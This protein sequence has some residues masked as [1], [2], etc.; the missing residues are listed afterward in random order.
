MV[1]GVGISC[2]TGCWDASRL[3]VIMFVVGV[4]VSWLESLGKGG[5]VPPMEIGGLK[6]S[7]PP[8][9]GDLDDVGV[10]VCLDSTP[11]EVPIREASGL[12]GTSLGD[13]EHSRRVRFAPLL[14]LFELDKNATASEG[15]CEVAQLT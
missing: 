5:W 13:F 12:V 1:D 4:E 8:G 14:P 6:G 15:V 2:G 9:E 3:G 7:T 10:R 11:F